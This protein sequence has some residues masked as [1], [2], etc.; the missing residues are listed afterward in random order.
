MRTGWFQSKVPHASLPTWT[1]LVAVVKC[2]LS[3]FHSSPPKAEVLIHNTG[4]SAL[5]KCL[6]RQVIYIPKDG[7]PLLIAPIT[8]WPF[9][10]VC[11]GVPLIVASSILYLVYS[12]LKKTPPPFTLNVLVWKIIDG[13]F[14]IYLQHGMNFKSLILR[15]NDIHNPIPTS[16]LSSIIQAFPPRTFYSYY[17]E[18][19]SLPPFLTQDN[20]GT[21]SNLP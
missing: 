9:L 17:T 3:S 10:P 1:S 21:G 12:K 14:I 15:Y 5:F 6:Q 19:I 2:I 8:R 16:Y 11:L 13:W 7:F 20:W 18:M 4:S